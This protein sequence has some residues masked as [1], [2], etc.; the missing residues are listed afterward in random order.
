MRICSDL[1]LKRADFSVLAGSPW[2]WIGAK[3]RLLGDNLCFAF[4]HKLLS[5]AFWGQ[6][7]SP[8]KLKSTIVLKNMS[9]AK[10]E[11]SWID[12]NF[13][14][15]K[16]HKESLLTVWGK[17]DSLSVFGASKAVG[18]TSKEEPS[19]KKSHGVW[20]CISFTIKAYKFMSH[21]KNQLECWQS[22]PVML[23]R[24]LNRLVLMTCVTAWRQRQSELPRNCSLVQMSFDG[25]ESS[26]LLCSRPGQEAWILNN[27]C[28]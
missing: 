20:N 16:L 9:A 4:Y 17:S 25:V 1:C 2:C 26:T 8:C 6:A 3:I 5:S 14:P 11:C 19:F 15:F 21:W 18:L 13:P 22:D 7:R 28:V 10:F 12:M 27:A 23:K 24:A